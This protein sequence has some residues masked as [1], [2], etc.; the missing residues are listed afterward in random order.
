MTAADEETK[1]SGLR[2]LE[3]TAS[4]DCKGTKVCENMRDIN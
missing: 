1:L 4:K 3:F 2:I